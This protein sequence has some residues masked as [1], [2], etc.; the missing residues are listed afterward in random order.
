M[1]P[2]AEIN[3]VILYPLKIFIGFIQ[4]FEKALEEVKLTYENEIKIINDSKTKFLVLK[5]K[6][7]LRDY[8]F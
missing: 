2:C 7:L 8:T 3:S 6:N 1:D 5:F 4:A